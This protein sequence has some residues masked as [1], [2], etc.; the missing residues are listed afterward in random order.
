MS[1]LQL[2]LHN[3]D[4][5]LVCC[6][7][8]NGKLMGDTVEKWVLPLQHGQVPAVVH[9]QGLQLLTQLLSL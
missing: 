3:L 7:R 2:T 4:Q 9:Q 6:R 1:C 8:A 5:S